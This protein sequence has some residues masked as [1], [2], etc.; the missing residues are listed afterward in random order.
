MPDQH[1]LLTTEETAALLRLKPQTLAVWRL[2]K[3]YR[4][5]YLKLGRSIRYR[6]V[7]VEQF[8]E[9]SYVE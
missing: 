9:K 8:V 1:D 2:N 6:R 5:P 7:D 3:S 4:L